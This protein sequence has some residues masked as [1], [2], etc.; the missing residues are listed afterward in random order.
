MYNPDT[1][2]HVS[3]LYDL[4]YQRQQQS[5]EQVAYQFYD[6]TNKNWQTQTWQQIATQV[7]NWQASLQQQQLQAGDRIAI[8]LK[9]SVEWV[10]ADQA[11]MGLNLVTVPLYV[12]DRPDNITYILQDA[13]VK[14]LFI[15]DYKHWQRLEMLCSNATD[16]QKVI[17]INPLK[18]SQTLASDKVISLTDWLL[19]GDSLQTVDSNQAKQLASIVYT[20]GTTGRPKGVMLS[21]YN[22]LSI[23]LAGLQ[24]IDCDHNDSF[25]SFLPL[26][27]TLERTAG[28]YLPMMAG[29][30]VS[31]A[32]S[33]AQLAN[34]L[35]RLKPTAMVAVPRVFE[36][37][38]EKL[39]AKLT[40]QSKLSQTIFNFAI[41]TGWKHFLYQQGRGSYSPSTLLM[42]L[43]NKFVATPL[44]QQFGGNLRLIVS[45]G[46]PLSQDIAKIFIALGMPILQ[47]YGLTETSPVISVNTP[48][49]NDPRSV[50]QALPGITVKIGDKQELLVKTPGLMLGYWNLPEATAQIIDR[51]GWLHTGD[52][53]KIENDYIYITGRIKDI[54]ILSNGEKIPPSDM[55]LAISLH[56]L[57]EQVMIIGEGQAQLAALVILQAEQ[58]QDFAKQQQVDPDAT[59][60]LSKPDIHTAILAIINQQLQD[61]PG[62]AKVRKLHLSLTPWTVEN[63]LITPTMKLKRA[64][65]IEHYQVI[66]DSLYE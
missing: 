17:I 7:A 55:E 25:L 48:E 62:Y 52:Q 39:Q 66:I 35:Q 26:S 21:H 41:T 36:R 44:Q 15:Q 31:Y 2:T 24:K 61:F 43:L 23:C 10:L 45:G 63:G 49:H 40:Q 3:T 30:K 58:W 18:S 46:A 60:S 20:S 19:S 16:L 5:A 65:I 37:I 14:C 8:L 27:H 47:G 33:I 38:Y 64:K 29:A 22:M 13:Q 11:T 4:F 9:N 12:E 53:A 42:P 50:G 32:R 51:E 54:L 59:E 57:I 6:K 1:L 56:P 28:Y 34:D